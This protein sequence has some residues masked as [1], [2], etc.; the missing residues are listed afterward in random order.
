M[1]RRDSGS[2]EQDAVS[3]GEQVNCPM[4]GSGEMPERIA[5]KTRIISVF[6]ATAISLAC[7]TN[8][9]ISK[10]WQASCSPNTQ[11]AYSAWAPEYASRMKLSST[12]SNLI[13]T[14]GNL[15]RFHRNF[16]FQVSTNS[17]QGM[18]AAGIPVGLLVDAK[19]PRPG[20][21]LGGLLLGMGYLI[22]HR[23]TVCIRGVP[24]KH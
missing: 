17:H 23:G 2:S 8:V 1:K 14:F 16:R 15:G 21:M 24:S 20:V 4:S 12:Q 10:H 5:K 22:L 9:R 6:A 18:Y 19:G 3:V 7:G 13:G 11:Y